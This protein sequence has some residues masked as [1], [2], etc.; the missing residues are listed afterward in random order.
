MG[1]D[2][3]IK[4]LDRQK[5]YTG[6]EVSE[7]A[8]DVGYF[9]DC[10]NSYGLFAIMSENLG[11]LYSW[12]QTYRERKELFRK[13]NDS[14]MT[15]SGAKKWLAELEP[16]IERFKKVKKMRAKIYDFEANQ[17]RQKETG[18]M[19]GLDD[20]IYKRV[21]L[22]N[23]EQKDMIEHGELLIRFLKLEIKLRSPIIWSV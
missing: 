11:E 7:R 16:A 1:A 8:V 23:E 20:I 18:K 10:Y 9:R 15:V 12:W 13:N 19:G 6:F 22:K 21:A 4:N 14:Q 3:Y 5:Q 17:K 2:L